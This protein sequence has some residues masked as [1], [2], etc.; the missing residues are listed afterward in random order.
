MLT[1]ATAQEAELNCKSIYN[2]NIRKAEKSIKK[3]IHFYRNGTSYF[4]GPGSGFQITFEHSYDSLINWLK[5][6]SC[7]E[8]AFSD[9]YEMKPG[10]FPGT[11]AVGVKFIT[12]KGVLEQCFKI[13]EGKTGHV[14]FFG[15]RPKLF[16]EKKVLVYK[17]MSNCPGFIERQK[18]YYSR[19]LED[20]QRMDSIVPQDLLGIWEKIKSE[21]GE[22]KKEI[23]FRYLNNDFVLISSEGLAYFFSNAVSGKAVSA[24]G[25]MPNWPPYACYVKK[26]GEDKIQVEYKTFGGETVI[27]NYWK[28]KTNK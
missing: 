1:K 2:G 4:N 21:D 11:S 5:R 7:V 28:Q 24:V 8:E 12:R 26:M 19:Q 10:I 13:Q 16:K 27:C 9:K 6:Q 15:W 14:N 3:Q 20:E 25:I 17:Y 18:Y 22:P 23:E